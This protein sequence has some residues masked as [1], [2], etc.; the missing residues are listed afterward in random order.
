MESI[1]PPLPASGLPGTFSSVG[2]F[3]SSVR[4]RGLLRREGTPCRVGMPAGRSREEGRPENEER[5]RM[6]ENIVDGNGN[7]CL[8]TGRTFP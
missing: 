3:L 8:N 4:C 5:E 6:E 2:L 1:L 7:F